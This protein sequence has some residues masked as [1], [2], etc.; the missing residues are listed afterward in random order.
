MRS[1]PAEPAD[2]FPFLRHGDEEIC[3][4]DAVIDH[5]DIENA[6]MVRGDDH[7]SGERDVFL[8]MQFETGD[9]IEKD[10]DEEAQ[11][12]QHDYGFASNSFRRGCSA[13]T[14]RYFSG[15]RAQT[16]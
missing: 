14:P 5:D 7:P 4:V 15:S 13:Y 6:D 12:S 3:A 16:R 1:Q 9:Q 2:L 10:S 8:P 11:G